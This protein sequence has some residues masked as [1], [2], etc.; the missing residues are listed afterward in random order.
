LGLLSICN[1]TC[2]PLPEVATSQLKIVIHE[3]LIYP[4]SPR[5]PLWNLIWAYAEFDAEYDLQL[6]F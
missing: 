5:F 3:L 2:P 4:A 6:C 1:F